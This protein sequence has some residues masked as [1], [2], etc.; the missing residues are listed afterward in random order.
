VISLPIEYF[1]DVFND[2][3]KDGMYLL[4]WALRAKASTHIIETIL[5]CSPEAVHRL[6]KNSISPIQ[7]AI[8]EGSDLAIFDLLLQAMKTGT[9]SRSVYICTLKQSQTIVADDSAQQEQSLG[10]GAKV[11]IKAVETFLASMQQEDRGICKIP[12]NFIFS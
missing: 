12:A 11:R 5:S 2:V 3:Q 7:Y 6:D 9:R 1:T 10:V 8:L 4:H